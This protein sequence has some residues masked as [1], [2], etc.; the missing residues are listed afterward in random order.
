MFTDTKSI[1]ISIRKPNSM[2]W[3]AILGITATFILFVP[4]ILVLVYHLYK[5]RSFLALAIYF[6]VTGFYNLTQQNILPTPKSF[7]YYFGLTGNLLDAPLMLI[8]LCSFCRSQ[9]MVNRIK[10]AIYGFIAYEIVMIAI[11]GM[12]VKAITAIL[13]PDLVVILIPTF[14]FF[15]RQLKLIVTLQ[16]GLSKTLMI[17][18]VLFAYMLFGLVY[19][20]YYVLDTPDKGDTITMYYITSLLSTIIMCIGLFSENK[21]IQKINELKNTRKELASIYNGPKTTVILKSV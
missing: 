19:L 3:Q 8:F 5:Y 13:G 7:N 6:F 2:N 11:W 12:N 16:K 21:R 14:I 17:F 4:V 15:L 10:Y 9:T 20:F 1:S 18:S